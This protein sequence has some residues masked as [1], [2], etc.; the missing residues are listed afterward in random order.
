M[1]WRRLNKMFIEML[2]VNGQGMFYE[3]KSSELRPGLGNG[4]SLVERAWETG[5]ATS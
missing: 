2:S 1:L 3:E 5:K 4:S